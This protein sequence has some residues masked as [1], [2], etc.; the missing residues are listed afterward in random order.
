[1]HVILSISLNYLLPLYFDSVRLL[2][3][4]CF[5]M[6]LAFEERNTFMLISLMDYSSFIDSVFSNNVKLALYM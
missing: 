3:F 2:F 5:E 4:L 1:M 6:K